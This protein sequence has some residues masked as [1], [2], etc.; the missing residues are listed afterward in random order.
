[1]IRVTT[2]GVLRSYKYNLSGSFKNLNNS[3]DTVLTQRNFNSYMED[4]ATASKAFQ[5]RRSL[6]RVESQYSVNQTMENKYD[7]GWKALEGVQSLIKSYNTGDNATAWGTVLEGLDDPKGDARAALGKVLSQMAE[8]VTQSMNA[9]YGDNFI[10]AGADG[11]NVPFELKKDGLYFRGVQVDVPPAVMEDNGAKIEV[12][13]TG[14]PAAGGGYYIQRSK[15]TVMTTEEYDE[16]VADGKTPT[17][18]VD[19]AGKPLIVNS[20][21]ED[22]GTSGGHYLVIDDPSSQLITKQD[23]EDAE[24]ALEKLDYMCQDETQY[25]DIGLGMQENAANTLIPASAFNSALEGIKYLGYG[26]DEDGDP[27]NIVSLLK[28]M[29]S[30]LL[31]FKDGEWKGSAEWEDFNRL[32]G[33]FED[34]MAKFDTNFTELSAATTKLH[35]NGKLLEEDAYNLQSQVADLEDVDMAEAI[36]SLLYAQ[37]CY[38]ASLKVGNSILSQSLMDYM[39]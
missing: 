28:E 31:E 9:K 32:A 24:K 29:G 3:W 26:V 5:L 16:L 38:N 30:M 22:V 12:D 23:Y 2:N 17:L 34:A 4:P 1:M 27:K 35:N 10:F 18:V 15:L 37:Y 7:T 36:T 33:K 39:N 25:V 13:A 21:K 19:S 11:L 8:T 20:Q 6:A 14:T